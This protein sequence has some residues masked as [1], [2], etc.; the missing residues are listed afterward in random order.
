MNMVRPMP[1]AE[2]AASAP[3]PPAAARGRA[4]AW[5]RTLPGDL[6]RILSAEWRPRRPF[7]RAATVAAALAAV[8]GLLILHGLWL[9]DADIWF[10]EGKP[11][12]ILSGVLLGMASW[13]AYRFGRRRIGPPNG[14][15]WGIMAIVFGLAAADEIFKLHEHTEILLQYLLGIER[16]DGAPLSELDGYLVLV[17][18]LIGGVAGLIYRRHVARFPPTVRWWAAGA[19]LFVL[20]QLLDTGAIVLPTFPHAGILWEE[21]AKVLAVICL[22]AGMV[23]VVGRNDVPDPRLDAP[24]V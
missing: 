14:V 19:A 22:F 24:R 6:A 20:M 7:A 10:H 3:A 1:Q 11:A 8:V 5:W 16:R 12:T 9:G 13:S 18:P 15:F 23:A 2:H 4:A 21:V 17:Y